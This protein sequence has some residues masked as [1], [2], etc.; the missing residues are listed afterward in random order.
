MKQECK[1][2]GLTPPRVRFAP[3]PTGRL[4]LGSARTALFNWLFSRG[5]GGAMVLRLED[6]DRERSSEEFER[7]IIESL[8]WMGLDWDE[9]PDV[10]GHHGP[11]RQSERTGIYR[12]YADRLLDA[13]RAYR[14]YCTHGEL[15]QR[16]KAA[17]EKGLPWRYDRRCLALS[18]QERERL[19]QEGKP[20]ATRF[21]VPEGKVVVNDLL[22]GEVAVDASEID[23]F[24][25]LRSDGTAGFHLA[26]VVD[27]TTM[28]ITHVIRGDDHLT[29]AVRHVLLFN[30]F[31]VEPPLFLHHS[32]L[33]GPDGA[34]LSKRHYATAV[35]DYRERG[36]LREALVNYLA[37]LSWSPGDDREIFSL[38]ELAREFSIKGVSAS[39]AIFDLE[40]LNWLNRQHMKMRSDAEL[41]DLVMPFL[42]TA[43]RRA[44]LDLPRD[45]LEIAVASVR[46][47][48]ETLTDAVE[49]MDLYV[50]PAGDISSEAL[51]E[52]R[53]SSELE[54]AL[55]VCVE[56]LRANVSSDRETAERIVKLLREEARSRGWGAK[57]VLWPLRLA[58]T[59][60]TVGPDLVYLIMFW[61]PDVCAERINAT[62]EALGGERE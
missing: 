39:K 28:E 17:I 57:K 6:T 43:G 36:Y 40:K 14:C 51:G 9:G 62:R 48:M 32:L 13:G 3:S 47:G 52:L 5:S 37:L 33:M 56:V 15:D 20:Y 8:H 30:A 18:E 2:S 53:G 1:N 26:V 44:V 49:P 58:V 19:E 59:G 21:L 25:I 24:V 23:D 29:N 10:G 35:S 4:H 11:Y 27:D 22:R 45:K 41:T 16:Q 7:D 31:G 38:P 50:R 54:E 60:L 61:G 46:N 55:V 34:K 42:E 12:E